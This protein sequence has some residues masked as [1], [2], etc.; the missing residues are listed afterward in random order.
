MTVLTASSSSSRPLLVILR[1]ISF[2]SKVQV[3][4]SKD[5]LRFSVDDAR[6]MQG[7]AFLDKSLFTAY[8]FDAR[9]ARADDPDVAE[10]DALTPTFQ[11][12]LPALLE[13]LQ[14]FGSA[15]QKESSF[16]RGTD[17]DFAS[18]VNG[19]QHGG[20]Q[21]GGGG[22]AFDSRTLGMA[23]LC[24]LTYEGAG[25]PLRILLEE[26]AVTTTCDLA[27]YEP[28]LAADIPFARDAVELKVVMPA[29]WL[30][31]AV[32]EL[33]A[34]APERVTVTA[35]PSSSTSPEAGSFGKHAFG[36][37]AT[38]AHGSASVEF[39]RGSAML[40][41]FQAVRM[42]R[43][44][45]KFAMLKA[46]ARAMLAASKISIRGDAQ[47]VMNMQ[48]MIEG[49]GGNVSFVDFRFVPFVEDDDGGL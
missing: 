8:T 45:Y 15:D 29:A 2:S 25:H 30:L 21:A 41:T 12:S 13:A 5:G 18:G 20:L 1:C 10:E 48:F 26:G 49:D 40:E 34:V 11:L 38:G 46:A 23:G 35:H 17:T 22:V 27:A 42:V 24:R 19:R 7:L 9:A 4:I 44:T 28:E 43:N 47:G 32:S 39:E 36:M 33:S 14:I 16:G 31:D 37:S 3:Q 6:A